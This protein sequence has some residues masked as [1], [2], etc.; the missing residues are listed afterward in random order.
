MHGG[1]WVLFL[2]ARVARF[3][4]SYL[5]ASSDSQWYSCPSATPPH[6]ATQMWDPED[7]GLGFPA[8]KMGMTVPTSWALEVSKFRAY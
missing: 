8:C 5:K 1:G 3:S 4:G 6:I 2:G 7:L